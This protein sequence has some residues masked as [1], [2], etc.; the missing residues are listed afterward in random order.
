MGN[1]IHESIRTERWAPTM[2][3]EVQNMDPPPPPI[4]APMKGTLPQSFC[5]AVVAQAKEEDNTHPGESLD[6]DAGGDSA[7]GGT[8]TV[9][10]RN[11]LQLLA[12]QTLSG[13]E[14]DISIL[15]V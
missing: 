13:E 6:V 9:D 15:Y 1:S 7:P 4:S 14:V 8:V 5:S 11:R 2:E 12:D 10:C 3:F